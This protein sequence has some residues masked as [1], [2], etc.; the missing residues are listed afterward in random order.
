MSHLHLPQVQVLQAAVSSE[1]MA[2]WQ[3]QVVDKNFAIIAI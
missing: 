1:A 2:A 3:S